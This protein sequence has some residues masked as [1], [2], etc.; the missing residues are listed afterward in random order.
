MVEVICLINKFFN[1]ECRDVFVETASEQ[2]GDS[3]QSYCWD[4]DVDDFDPDVGHAIEMSRYFNGE[5]EDIDTTKAASYIKDDVISDVEDE[6]DSQL[7]MLP[8]DIEQHKNYTKHLTYSIYGAEDLINSHL[9]Y[10]GYDY[11]DY[12]ET[13]GYENPNLEIEYIFDRD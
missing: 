4:L 3:I 7:S 2:L 11:D 5:Y 9:E 10:D 8:E 6:I 1:G 12:R 13:R